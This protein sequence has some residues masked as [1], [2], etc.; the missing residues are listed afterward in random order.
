MCL[1]VHV[2]C[3]CVCAARCRRVLS[4]RLVRVLTVG[5]GGCVWRLSFACLGPKV[6]S[7]EKLSELRNA[8]MNV[9]ELKEEGEKGL[10]C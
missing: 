3:Y 6:N 9:G 2:C 5:G 10:P 8:G 7:V 4:R 1:C